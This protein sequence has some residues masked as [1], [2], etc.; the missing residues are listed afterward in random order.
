MAKE[1]EKKE[2]D[3]EVKGKVYSRQTMATTVLLTI[4]FTLLFIITVA[5][6][7]KAIA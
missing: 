5:V 2:K 4:F 7:Y 6:L 1:V 3:N